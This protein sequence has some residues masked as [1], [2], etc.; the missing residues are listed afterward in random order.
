MGYDAARLEIISFGWPR[1]VPKGM[2][3]KRPAMLVSACPF[4][5]RAF[6]LAKTPRIYATFK[7]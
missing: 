4:I 1:V 2:E 6:V 3:N 7:S 5:E